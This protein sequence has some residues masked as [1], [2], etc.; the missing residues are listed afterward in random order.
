MPPIAEPDP[1]PAPAPVEALAIDLAGLL[2]SPDPDHAAELAPGPELAAAVAEAHLTPIA[3]G[4]DAAG[5]I[6]E[7]SRHRSRNPR[8]LGLVR[9]GA[10]RRGRAPPGRRPWGPQADPEPGQLR[11]LNRP[12]LCRE[13]QGQAHCPR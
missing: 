10:L 11:G 3:L 4:Q 5:E 9:H 8:P 13:R 7:D 1:E 6:R 12:E 2:P